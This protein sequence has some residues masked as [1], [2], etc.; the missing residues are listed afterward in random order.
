MC[1]ASVHICCR[2]TEADSWVD[3]YLI[4]EVWQVVYK[5]AITGWLSALQRQRELRREPRLAFS[6]F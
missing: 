2:G 4:Q 6:P 5:A 3:A 1:A